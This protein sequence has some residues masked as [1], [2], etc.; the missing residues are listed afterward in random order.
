[1]QQ[2][3]SSA[4]KNQMSQKYKSYTPETIKHN[5][6][7]RRDLQGWR[8]L[9]VDASHVFNPRAVV[10]IGGGTGDKI[11]RFLSKNNDA[12][13]TIV[14][15]AKQPKE[16]Q[17]FLKE[18]KIEYVNS[19]ADGFLKENQSMEGGLI[20]MFGFLHEVNNLESFLNSLVSEKL[21]STDIL[22]SDNDLYFD[23]KNLERIIAGQVESYA[24][25]EEKCFM[26]FIHY[27]KFNKRKIYLFIYLKI[28]SLMTIKLL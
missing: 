7:S 23:S 14:D 20:Y 4:K 28:I 11:Y 17:E 21:S 18:K 8:N 6:E 3:D 27:Y 16:I 2:L 19:S 22:I 1:M 10:D 5:S 26:K 24:V 9:L 15:F 12:K 25:Y 13:F